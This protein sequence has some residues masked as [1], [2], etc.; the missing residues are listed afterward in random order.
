VVSPVHPGPM[1]ASIPA[2]TVQAMIDHARAGVPNEA[3]GLII[4]DR[5]AADGGRALQIGRAHV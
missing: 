3:C 5:P 4:G 1:T 2:T